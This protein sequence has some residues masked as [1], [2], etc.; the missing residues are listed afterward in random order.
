MKKQYAT[1][2]TIVVETEL[3]SHIM[4]GSNFNASVQNEDFNSDDMT[5]LSRSSLW[6]KWENNEE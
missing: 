5:A 2:L 1:P 4:A 3:G 6:N